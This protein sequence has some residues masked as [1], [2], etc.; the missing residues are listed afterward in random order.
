MKLEKIYPPRVI[1]LNCKVN[2]AEDRKI[3]EV[4]KKHRWKLG[5]FVRQ[6]VLNEV[7]RLE[8]EG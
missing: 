5:A 8:K 3:R 6:A 4:V 7:I 1:T 2:E